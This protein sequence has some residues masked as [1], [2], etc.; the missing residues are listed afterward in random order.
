M[1]G[2]LLI[3]A[4]SLL[5]VVSFFLFGFS[6]SAG[7]T[8]ILLTFPLAV[9]LFAIVIIGLVIRLER[10]AIFTKFYKTA[11]GFAIFSFTSFFF[12]P[13]LGQ[14]S[15]LGLLGP[16]NIRS[17][18]DELMASC[19]SEGYTLLSGNALIPPTINRMKPFYVMVSPQKVV[20]VNDGWVS[21]K[22]GYSIA[23]ESFSTNETTEM[24]YRI[25]RY[26]NGY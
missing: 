19:S 21:S 16:E 26:D 6:P 23:S 2:A 22:Y 3:I 10:N 17:E 8:L 18:A 15:L 20:V 4:I 7:N 24:L 12:M 1:V 11:V 14:Y 9:I 13:K 5:N 25:H